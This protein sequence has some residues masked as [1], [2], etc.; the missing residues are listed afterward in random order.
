MP[1]LLCSAS[2][3]VMLLVSVFLKSRRKRKRICGTMKTSSYWAS[4]SPSRRLEVN[5]DVGCLRRRISC[6]PF[7][8]AALSVVRADEQSSVVVSFRWMGYKPSGIENF[9]R[10]K[11]CQLFIFFNKGG[12]R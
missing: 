3:I 6:C 10:C 1:G 9:G 2:D 4:Q 7:Q 5:I 12:G 11:Y 8:S